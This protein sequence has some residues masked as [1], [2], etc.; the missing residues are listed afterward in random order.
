MLLHLQ[1][2]I[3]VFDRPYTSFPSLRSCYTNAF[4]TPIIQTN[5]KSHALRW[6]Y[7]LKRTCRPFNPV[8][9]KVRNTHNPIVIRDKEQV[10]SRFS[11]R[12][13]YEDTSMI[14]Q[15]K[16]KVKFL[17]SAKPAY[18]GS[19]FHVSYSNALPGSR[20]CWMWNNFGPTPEA[21]P[22]H[23]VSSIQ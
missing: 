17:S 12:S 16:A 23:I 20:R 5:T 9:G 1:H 14:A 11:R 18:A 21:S 4:R 13:S 2:D 6:G 10:P 3:R 22:M 15:T 19:L 7:E 8:A